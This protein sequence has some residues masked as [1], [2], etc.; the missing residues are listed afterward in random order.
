[1][2]SLYWPFGRLGRT[3]E[4]CIYPFAM[5]DSAMVS[6][7]VLISIVFAGKAYPVSVDSCPMYGCRPF[8]TFSYT[9]KMTSNVGMAWPRNFIQGALTNSLG[10]AANNINIVCQAKGLQHEYDLL[11]LINSFRIVALK[12]G[13]IWHYFKT[14]VYCTSYDIDLLLYF[15]IALNEISRIVALKLHTSIV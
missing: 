8:G 2:I 7:L 10:C 1:M 12:L 13:N 15:V 9:L 14:Y 11:F 3:P 6:I 4:T 5:A